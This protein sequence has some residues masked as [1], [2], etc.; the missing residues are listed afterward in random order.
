MPAHGFSD[1]GNPAI[2]MGPEALRPTVAGGLPFSAGA[3]SLPHSALLTI[4]RG[5]RQH[6]KWQICF[7]V[8]QR[9]PSAIERPG[10]PSPPPA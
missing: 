9:R 8:F 7:V 4:P 2:P 5:R 1:F 3:H 6:G 10:L